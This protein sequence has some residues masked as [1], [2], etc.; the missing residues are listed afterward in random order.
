MKGATG[1]PVITDGEQKKYHNFWTYCVHGLS[2]TAPDGFKIPFAAGHTRRMPRL[3]GGPFRYHMYADA[4]LTTAFRYAHKPVKQAVIS[5]SALSL[6]YPAVEIPGYTRQQFIVDLIGEHEI[7]VR[8]CLAKGA[9]KVQVDFT[10]GRLAVKIDPSG[11][12]LHSFID[13]NNLALSRFSETDRQCIGVHTCPGGDRDSTHSADADYA[14]L[15]PSLFELMVGNFYI[16]LA[17]ERDRLRVLRI[18]REHMKPS[19]RI[20]VGVV[21]P[22]DPRIETAEEVRDRILEAA[23]YIP[24]GQLGTTD[25]C[26]FSPFCDDTSTT[27]ETAFEKIRARVLGTAPGLRHSRRQLM[28]PTG[29]ERGGEEEQLQHVALQNAQSILHAR[30]RAEEELRRQSEWLRVTL[31]SI[32]DGVISTDAQ[33]RVSFMNGVAMTLTG[34]PLAEA[35]GRPL[36]DVFHIVN[37]A[38]RLPVENPVVRALRDGIIVGL[39]NHTVLI[40]RDGAER[41]I[42]DSAAPIRTQDGEV[43]GCVLVF[44][45]VTERNRALIRDKFL[46]HLDDAIRPMTDPGQITFAAAR[47]LG[48]HLGVDRCA[49]AEVEADED[50][51]NLTGNYTRSPEI[52]SIVGRMRFADFGDEVLRLMRGDRPFVVNDVDTHSPPVGDPVAYRAT[53]IQAVICVPLHKSGRFVAAM[54]VHSVTPRRWRP[55]EVE[56]VQLVADRCWESIERAR[57]ARE[58]ARHR[59]QLQELVA[60]RTAE[61]QRASERLRISE[62]MASLG[63]LAAGLGHDMGNLLFPLRV[64]LETLE[65][66][67]LPE[68]ARVELAGIRG[69]ADYIKRLTGGLRLLAVDPTR[70]VDA[71]STDLR[72]WWEEVEALLHNALPQGVAL[73][74]RLP[75]GECW[76]RMGRAP[77]TQVIF[78]LVQ[79][80]GDAMRSIRPGQVSVWAECDGERVRVGVTDNGPG[81]APEVQRQCMEPFFTTK[82]R[83]LSTGL[84]LVLV[85]GLVKEAG[86]TV[87]LASEPGRGTT[88]LLS[89]RKDER[90]VPKRSAVAPRRAAVDVADP[91]IRSIVSTEL[92]TLGYEVHTGPVTPERPVNL[93]VTDRLVGATSV[94]TNILVLDEPW[95][96]PTPA[97]G[98]GRMPSVQM[99]KQTLRGMAAE[100]E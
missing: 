49:Y 18:I 28:A 35:L 24:V 54:A 85:Y 3:T 67:D 15:L 47:I 16:A 51:M 44:R 6:M 7:E 20:F 92:R 61:L 65:E 9:H 8:A 79:N 2:N 82:P 76:V 73:T 86:G 96:V 59:D 71:E 32:G 95:A 84:G 78:N 91:R 34:W 23:E 43:L 1:S 74:S 14:E 41:P 53:Q 50:T 10:E 70:S 40:A 64:R 33:G 17:G 12:L 90:P 87:D 4:Y 69:T 72:T 52:K 25:D 98:V 19:Q 100:T 5:P 63:T 26:G 42:D 56:L 22:I 30:R 45:D 99:L 93:M 13:L 46:V 27:R 39:A 89:L 75:S 58:L 62:R 66:M 21:S 60:E 94:A 29:G 48:E 83:G 37:E 11:E 57:V 55:E 77:L 38:T 81:M 36:S 68:A 80:A 97:I 88:F 31:S